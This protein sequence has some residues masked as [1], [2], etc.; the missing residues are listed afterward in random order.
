[1]NLW[2]IFCYFT[3]WLQLRCSHQAVGVYHCGLLECVLWLT[4][5]Q[6]CSHE[7]VGVYH[8]GLLEC[9]LWLTPWQKC[10]HQAVGACH[11]GLLECVLHYINHWNFIISIKQEKVFLSVSITYNN[12]YHSE[13]I[14]LLFCFYTNILTYNRNINI[15]MFVLTAIWH[16]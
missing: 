9:A 12:L 3:N 5:W 4:P 7:A 15:Y 8:C 16:F 2:E 6:K 11:C 10:S 1:M 13:N 14:H